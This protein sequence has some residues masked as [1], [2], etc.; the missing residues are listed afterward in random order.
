MENYLGESRESA[1]NK[2]S[3]DPKKQKMV[4]DLDEEG[5]SQQY[6]LELALRSMDKDGFQMSPEERESEIFKK[7]EQSASNVIKCLDIKYDFEEKKGQ[8]IVIVTDEAVTPMVLEAFKEQALKAVDSKDLRIVV[9][10]VPNSLGE[11]LGD[12]IGDK[13]LSA[14]KVILLTS[15]SRTHSKEVKKIWGGEESD[16]E[17]INR[18]KQRRKKER[19]SMFGGKASVF[20]IT[21]ANDLSLLT[22]GAVLEDL[23]KM[24]ERITKFKEKFKDA[25]KVFITTE[26][27]T[28][29]ELVIKEGTIAAEDGKLDKPGNV[30]NFPFGEVGC[31]PSFEGTNGVLVVDGVG[32]KA[33]ATTNEGY[34]HEPIK[35]FI[36]DGV[37]VRMEGGQ[38]AEDFWKYL[39][40]IQAKYLI[41]NPGGKG[42]VFRLAEF[43]FGMNNAAWRIGE[44]ES[45]KLPPT[46][47]EAEKALGTIHIALGNN[48]L[49]LLLGGYTSTDLEYNGIGFHSDQVIL[50]PSVIAEN[51]NGEKVEL[52]LQGQLQI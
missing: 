42:S 40:Q 24:W 20:S 50:E 21:R 30:A 43:S 10:G 45:K 28:N 8:N 31:A 3:L 17:D 49:S 1:F 39:E 25:K 4:D 52:I 29:L 32:G 19:G 11:S 23:E 6:D 13:I 26:K 12:G 16:N 22:E 9:S 14:D 44:N 38:E 37:V 15:K 51:K 18:L 27:G 34:I 48:A 2:L 46:Q 5:A 36:E 7:L 41:D 35:M 33:G 47:L